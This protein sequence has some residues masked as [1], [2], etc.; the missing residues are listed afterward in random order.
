MNQAHSTPTESRPIRTRRTMLIF[1]LLSNVEPCAT[2]R[3]MSFPEAGLA[4]IPTEV[5]R[6]VIGRIDRAIARVLARLLLAAHDLSL[7]ALAGVHPESMKLRSLPGRQGKFD[8]SHP[9][10]LASA[11]QFGSNR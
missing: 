5:I 9:K 8:P 6:Q 7:G 10:R 11:L 4:M 3:R 1:S 2:S